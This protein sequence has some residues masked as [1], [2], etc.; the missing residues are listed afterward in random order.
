MQAAVVPRHGGPE[1]IELQTLPIPQ[2]AAGEVLVAQ[3]TAGVNFNFDT[4][5][6]AANTTFAKRAPP[7]ISGSGV[8]TQLG[9]GVADL[10]EGGRVV[11]SGFG[12]SADP[13]A[14]SYAAYATPP[15]ATAVVLPD[16]AGWEAGC[17]AMV[18]GMTAHYLAFGAVPGLRDGEWALVHAAAGGTGRALVQ[19][20]HI[21][22][23]RVVATV[24]TEEKAA[25]VRELGVCEH[26]LLYG[27]NGG[28]WP[29]TVRELT[30]GGVGAVFD[31]V[32]RD[33]FL[34]GF[35]CLRIRGAMVMFGEASGAK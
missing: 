25:I 26:I 2:P 14:G 3:E 1:V 30:S 6:R 11:Y 17:T 24:S 15:A 13:I 10:R 27:A 12:A 28:D 7:F 4:H 21:R 8:V 20:L 18:N 35:E 31:G 9:F 32:G 29:S 16:A 23:V 33:T 5:F 22:G 19:A 34:R